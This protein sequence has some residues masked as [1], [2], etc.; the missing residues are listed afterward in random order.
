MIKCIATDMD[1][2]LLTSTDKHITQENRQAIL[3]AQSLGI[4]VVIATGRSYNEVNYLL[5][6]AGLRCPVIC[7]NGAEVRSK[8]GKVLLTAPL[9][10]PAASAARSIMT[11]N[12]IYFEVYTDRGKFTQDRDQS[13]AIIMDLYTSSNPNADPGEIMK[14]AKERADRMHLIDNYELLF[15]G[16]D[17]KI[18]KLLAFSFDSDKLYAVNKELQK[19]EDIVVSSSGRENLEI[20]DKYAQKGI[21]LEKLTRTLAI[22]MSE[23]MAIGDGFNDVSMFKRVGRS[24]AMG[25]ASDILKEQCDFVTATND[26]SGVAKAIWEVLTGQTAG[27]CCQ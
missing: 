15:D 25:N 26:E 6:K 5:E 27:K 4:E 23:T 19:V 13:I 2:T 20:N 12:G 7:A 22:P 10:K 3:H 14:Y 16:G 24:V 17:Y 18:Y 8:E 11:E 9:N 1:G 21:A